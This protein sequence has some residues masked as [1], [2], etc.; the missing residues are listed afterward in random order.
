MFT[1]NMPRIL[2]WSFTPVYLAASIVA[3]SSIAGPF[4]IAAAPP[5]FYFG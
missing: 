4:L 2:Q 1:F 3:G 5:S